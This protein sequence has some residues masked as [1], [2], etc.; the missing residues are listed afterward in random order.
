LSFVP[1]GT[2]SDD[3]IKVGDAANRSVV[4]DAFVAIGVFVVFYEKIVD[5]KVNGFLLNFKLRIDIKIFFCLLIVRVEIILD[6][7]VFAYFITDLVFTSPSIKLGW[8]IE[9]AFF[10]QKF[11]QPKST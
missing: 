6:N 10:I 8:S 7:P 11:A 4:F 9:K 1:D 5:G 2:I 3:R